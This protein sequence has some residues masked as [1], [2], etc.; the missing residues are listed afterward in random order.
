MGRQEFAARVE[1]FGLET[2]TP[3]AVPALRLLF[4]APRVY[5]PL[6]QAWD[7]VNPGTRRALDK[8]VSLGLVAFQA[9]VVVDTR[10]GQAAAAPSRRVP[11]YRTTSK[12]GRLLAAVNEDLAVLEDT[13]PRTDAQNT[14]GVRAML[15]AFDLQ[16][17]HARFGLSAQ[18]AATLSGLPASNVKWWVRQLKSKGYLRELEDKFADVREVIPAHWRITRALCRQVAQVLDA[19]D[20]APQA[21]RVEFRLSRSRFLADIDP[22]R[23][24]IS[25]ATD[26]DHDVQCQR[27]LAQLLRSPRAVPA[28][29]FTVEPKFAVP[30]RKNVIPW[31][32]GAPGDDLVFYQPDAELRERQDGH[33]VRTYLEYER[34]QVRRDGWSHIEKMLGH[35]ATATLP[36]EAAALRFVVDS[37]PRER[38]Y[39]ALLRSFADYALD[40]PDRMPV[41]QVTLHVSSAPRLAA[42]PD[43][44]AAGA[45]HSIRL[46]GGRA[47]TGSAPVLHDPND[48]PLGDYL[49]STAS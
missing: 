39:V 31:Q 27:V 37:V 4:S 28:G 45:W 18:H 33:L 17:S 42:A 49:K 32:F 10:T 43:P 34:Y 7:E 19:F 24:G 12:G 25:G 14:S 30:V 48:S 20:E 40:H 2:P 38:A 15:A 21:L 1:T 47:D 13:F 3:W 44:L 5:L 46:S 29:I 22:A 6:A 9:G 11:R 41:N 36:F 8:L 23:V 35:V 16:D 26:F